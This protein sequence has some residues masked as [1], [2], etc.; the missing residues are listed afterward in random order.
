MEKNNSKYGN[1]TLEQFKL[2]INKLPEI[3]GQM[4]ELPDLLNSAPKDRV[5]G[6]LDQGLYWADSYELS[7]Q[8]LLALLICALGC[9]QE[10]HK[11]AQSDDPTQAVFSMFQNVEYET[12]EGGLEGLFE[13]SDVV[14]L[15]SALQRNILS[16]MLFH[17]T[18]NAMVDEVRSGDDDSLFNAVRI[19]RSII[20]CPTF[21]LRISKAEVKNDRK[22]FIRL[23]SSLKGPSKKHWEA[24][25]DLR[26]AFFILRESG[27]NQMSDAQLEEL[28]IHQLKLYSNAPGARKNL[29]KQFTESKKF[30]TT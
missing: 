28:L 9:H 16:I 21:A 29:R 17:R 11:A 1:L 10:L 22:F 25:K 20:T 23:R 3:R 6:I 18:L 26:Y 19:D 13:I 27:F 15:F 12:W 14:G 7:F 4:Q 5:M 8:E 2:L 30:S 24:Y